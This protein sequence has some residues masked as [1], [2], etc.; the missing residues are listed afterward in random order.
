M[1]S[2][3]T[4]RTVASPLL[5]ITM[6]ITILSLIGFNLFFALYPYDRLSTTLMIVASLV[7]SGGSLLLF[8][9]GARRFFTIIQIDEN[10]ISRSL[11]GKLCRLN[12]KWNEIYEISYFES[13]MA[14]L[15]FSQT[16]SIQGLTYWKITK[17]KNL[18]QIQLTKKNYDFVK[19][20]IQQPIKGLTEDKIKQ[21]KL[22]K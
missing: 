11:F 18:I 12:M 20:F 14:F 4:R 3:N 1:S 8:I 22:E 13:G 21:L 6:I 16:R 15:I 10:G 5:L 9:L 19:Q 17:I 7:C 2:K